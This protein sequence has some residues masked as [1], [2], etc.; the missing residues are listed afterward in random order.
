M[1]GR[2]K[3]LIFST[4]YLPLVGGAEIAVKEITDRLPDCHFDMIT[5]KIQYGL[6]GYERVGRINVYRV[7]FGFGFD[8]FLLPFLG[9]WKARKLDYNIIWSIMA[10]QAGVAA[11]LLKMIT[12][13][14]MVLT[15]QE[16]DLESHLERYALGSKFLYNLLIKPW[17]LLPFRKADSIQAIS[18]DLKN[19]ALL[20]WVRAPIEIVPNGVDMEK[21]KHVDSD[22]KKKLGIKD[23][24]VILTAS[25][26]VEKN[27]VDD[28]IK[29][30]QYL[31][32]PFKMLIVGV[33]KEEKKLKEMARENVLFLGH[34]GHDELP[35]YYSIADVF[36]RASLSEGFGNVFLEAMA[37]GVPFVA[38]AVG[39]I[40]D[41]LRDGEIG[42]ECEVK[43]PQSIAEKIQEA[44]GSDTQK[45]IDLVKQKYTWD[46]IARQMEKIQKIL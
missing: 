13:K 17:H 18:R 40:K 1:Q 39:G 29:A 26:L 2:K 19:R 33:G 14:K 45:G 23:E 25:R 28:L 4:A 46:I 11:S 20:N 5:A 22:L 36:V 41:F 6:A 43:N 27:G 42:Y 8:K 35:K 9:L 21:F 24:K 15:L 16:G 7:G 32:F 3:I 30:G 12:S 31:K 44:I 37:C 38:P 34:I 10:S